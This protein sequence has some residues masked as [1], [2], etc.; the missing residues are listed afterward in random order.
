MGLDMDFF[1]S[2]M[3][4]LVKCWGKCLDKYGDYVEK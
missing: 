2:G 3:G 4:N 1:W